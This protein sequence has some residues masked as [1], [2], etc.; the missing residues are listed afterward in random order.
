M[1]KQVVARHG[2]H[3]QTDAE[4]VFV[5]GSLLRNSRPQLTQLA[6]IAQLDRRL[7]A[8]EV[9]LMSENPLSFD[10]RYF[11]TVPEVQICTPLI[12]FYLWR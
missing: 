1:I 12:P 5:N 6:T 10:A 8:G 3:V 11:G 9:L 2:D 4:G 7:E